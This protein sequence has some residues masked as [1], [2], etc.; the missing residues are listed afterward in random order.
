MTL[1][2][3]ATLRDST[4]FFAQAKLST[5]SPPNSN[6]SL[7]M[8]R[9]GD[10]WMFGDRAAFRTYETPDHISASIWF[11][12]FRSEQE[13]KLATKLLLKEHRVTGE[14][15]VKD[16]SGHVIGDR[17]VA[18]SKQEKK[19]FMVIRNQ[20]LD[21]W[22]TE[23]GSL[24]V[25]MQVDG[26]IEPPS[27]L[28][29]P[30]KDKKV[31]SSCDRSTEFLLKQ[32]QL[33]KEEQVHQMRAQ[34]QVGIMV[35]ADGDVVSATAMSARGIRVSS[36]EAIDLLV[37]QA[38]SMRFKPRPGCGTDRYAMFFAVLGN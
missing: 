34:G 18:A 11:G 15:H 6:Q 31:S 24:A 10:G 14:E 25:A 2:L 8:T 37:A 23:S 36:A 9:V 13:A 30:V 33:S 1:L 21:Y 22:I 35:D 29:A 20:G 12:K 26:L 3:F 7:T 32:Q 28:P 17:I 16:L 5:N 27:P 38:R 19:A 4:L